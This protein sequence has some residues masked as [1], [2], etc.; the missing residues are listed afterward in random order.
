MGAVAI[1]ALANHHISLGER[2]YIEAFDRALIGDRDIAGVQERAFR[3]LEEE[4]GRA[5]DMPRRQK[6]D[7]EARNRGQGRKRL[8]EP[9]PECAHLCIIP[10]ALIE[11]L[12]SCKSRL[13][14]SHLL[15]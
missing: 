4:H 11:R 9:G 7:G 1:G 5:Q 13:Q 14:L 15:F 6:A 3:G 8:L 12:Q 2:L 10:E